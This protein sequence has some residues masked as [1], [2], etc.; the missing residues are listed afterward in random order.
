M[1]IK[2]LAFGGVTILAATVYS[3]ITVYPEHVYLFQT[4]YAGVL[5]L[6]AAII[7]A[8]ALVWQ[9]RADQEYQTQQQKKHLRHVLLAGAPHFVALKSQVISLKQNHQNAIKN[10][11][12]P[13]KFQE[14]SFT[15]PDE[16]DL[17]ATEEGIAIHKNYCAIIGMI[18]QYN[19][20]ANNIDDYDKINA[21]DFIKEDKN[22]SG[23]EAFIESLD[24]IIESGDYIFNYI[25]ERAKD[26]I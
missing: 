13:P 1:K 18:S 10:K 5:A 2:A 9:T 22:K 20:V 17:A 4:L 25:R 24:I 6:T 8:T 21:F 11:T 15:P 16:F 12:P 23:R 26:Y 14:I 7:G 19:N 3:A